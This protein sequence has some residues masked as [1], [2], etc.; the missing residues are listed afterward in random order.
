MTTIND[1]LGLK[2]AGKRA[3]MNLPKTRSEAV[4]ITSAKC[5]A[6]TRTGA[7]PSKTQPGS[8]YCTWCNTVY[9]FPPSVDAVDPHVADPGTP[10]PRLEKDP[11]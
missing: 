6:C 8:L 9:A 10:S 2:R 5:P 3:M 7:R 1:K 11:A 4:K